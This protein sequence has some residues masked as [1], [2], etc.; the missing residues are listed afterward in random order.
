MAAS[1][2]DDEREPLIPSPTPT[3]RAGTP[4]YG[5]TGSLSKRVKLAGSAGVAQDDE[6]SSGASDDG[7]EDEDEDQEA[8][9]LG[10]AGTGDTTIKVARE[11]KEI[12]AMCL[13][14]ATA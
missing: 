7:D 3:L 5:A 11:F 6:G 8:S 12:W 13:G 1:I 9:G 4:R 2:P 14:L 10:R